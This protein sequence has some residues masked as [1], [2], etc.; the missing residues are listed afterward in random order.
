MHQLL[1]WASLASALPMPATPAENLVEERFGIT[2]ADPYR[3]LENADDPRRE[4]WIAAQRRYAEDATA[5]AERDAI[6]AELDA[7]SR[8][9]ELPP[10]EDADGQLNG[11][12][13]LPDRAPGFETRQL[14]TTTGKYEIKLTSDTRS[15]L[16]LLRVLDTTSSLYLADSLQ[17]KFAQTFWD[18][19]E[20]S[21]LY[22]T[23]RD[24]RTAGQFPYVARHVLGKLQSE[25]QILHTASL[26]EAGLALMR[27][28]TGELLLWEESGG[29]SRIARFDA[30]TGATTPIASELALPF[31]PFGFLEGKLLIASWTAAPLGTVDA[32]DLTSGVMTNI[33]PA[34]EL[35]LDLA[36]QTPK[37][38]LFLAYVDRAAHRL[39]RY[40]LATKVTTEIALPGMGSVFMTEG[41]D[42]DAAFA[43]SSY[44]ER[45]SDWTYDRATGQLAPKTPAPP[46][47]FTIAAERL[48]YELADGTKAPLWI[49]RRADLV[50]SATTPVY[51]YGYG[52]FGLNI[53]PTFRANDLPWLKRGGAVAIATLPGG[54]E[55][56]EAWHGAGTRDNKE[57]VF[58]AFAAAGR[59]LIG[60]G[61]TSR[62][63]LGIGGRS[64]GGLLAAATANLYPGLFAATVPE[65]G[66]L[67]LTRYQL[68]T[69]GKYWVD[70]YGDR[71]DEDDFLNL[72]R[73]SPYNALN[74]NVAYPSALIITADQDDRVV[75]AHSFK[76]AARLQTMVG[77]GASA[78]LWTKAGGSHSSASGLKNERLRETAMRWSFL[79]QTLR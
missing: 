56:G 61:L 2:V 29:R 73:L 1:L 57:A 37:G 10:R 8:I 25:D 14:R 76:F 40:D 77:P 30:A 34:R 33:I 42:G 43:Y 6:E 78:L 46:T 45:V 38:E 18:A 31:E 66:V 5:G 64:N 16:K 26:P 28:E 27:L 79:L 67:D 58:A 74:P 53:L 50:M 9:R 35:A 51:L 54:R 65:C 13:R 41:P 49:V 47:P 21:F 3:W 48:E 4:P 52:G 7:A 12:R 55:Y 60:R 36:F 69:G 39:F 20:T 75:P 59:F 68:F 17:V 72:Y 70:D 71:A 24:G 63:H 11:F 32:I 62:E 44:S 19:D 23:D 22:V 15:D